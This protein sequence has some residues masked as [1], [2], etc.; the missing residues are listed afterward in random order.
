MKQSYINNIIEKLKSINPYKVILFGSYAWGKPD[1]DSDIDLIVVTN[2]EFMPN[3][4]KEKS[5]IYLLVSKHLRTIREKIPI[6]LI[7]YTRP[8][9]KKFNELGSSFSKEILKKG[10]VLYETDK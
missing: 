10:K 5:E 6:D 4:F 8:M 7:V 3:N 1:K 2:D 9:Y